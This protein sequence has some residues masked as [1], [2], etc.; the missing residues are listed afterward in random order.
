MQDLPHLLFVTH[1][2][3]FP[4]D[5]GDRIR[6]YHLL[7]FLS[8][9][10]HV[11]LASLSDEPVTN[12]TIAQLTR[13]CRRVSIVPMEKGKWLRGGMEMLLGGTISE[14]A[15][16]STSLGKLIR[17]WAKDTPFAA[18]LA[19]ASSVAH[20]LRL[21]GL[22]SAAKVVDVVDVDSQKW[23]DYAASTGFP[24][25][26][27]YRL[28]G[29]RLR[30]REKQIAQ[31]ANAVTLVSDREATIL[32][33]LT[34]TRNVVSVTNGVDLRY[35]HPASLPTE[36]GCVFVGAL[37][38]HPNVD[39]ICWFAKT[40]WPELRHRRPEATLRV[41]GRR[42]V[43]AVQALSEVPGVEV[44]G[45]VPDVRPYLAE[46]SVVVAPLRIARGLQN[47]V[48]E[49][50]AAGKP[51][52]SSPA[53]LAGFGAPNVPAISCSSSKEWVDAITRLLGNAPER[54]SLGMA[55]RLFAENNHDWAACLQPMAGHL[56]LPVPT[57]AEELA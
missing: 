22:E 30:K 15:F 52:V 37:D 56:Q 46:S 54:R 14:G 34:G 19:S 32:R 51:V 24:K 39:G 10:A 28:E 47:K 50:M 38:Y 11:H 45:Q 21:P 57:V 42:P 25:S 8:Q 5:K 55:G 16:R 29:S 31:W 1:R 49:A 2:A 12:E 9:I 26:V 3:P 7:R 4:P 53:A 27:I 35:Y 41:V 17:Q 48:L 43:A 40:V 20:Y 23:F 13:L 33:D 6:T 44:I 36:S 18:A